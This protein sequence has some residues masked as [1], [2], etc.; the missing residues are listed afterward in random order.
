MDPHILPVL[1]SLADLEAFI[2]DGES[3]LLK[4]VEKGDLKGL[5]EIMGHLMALKER[6]SSTDEMFE[7]LKQTIELLKTYD[8]ELPETVFKQLE[9]SA[10]FMFSFFFLFFFC[11]LGLHMQHIEIPRLGVQSELQ[12]PAY[13]IVTA[14]PDP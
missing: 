12:L 10:K 3:G 5:V 8:Q 7:P 2:K 14:T 9:V 11:L 6:Q 1:L 4:K 13:S